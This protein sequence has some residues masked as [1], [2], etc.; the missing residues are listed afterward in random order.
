[1]CC[2]CT[3]SFLHWSRCDTVE[4]SLLKSLKD[5]RSVSD[6]L[7]VMCSGNFY[8][9]LHQSSLGDVEWIRVPYHMCT[10]I[11]HSWHF[12]LGR[13]APALVIQHMF[14]ISYWYNGLLLNT[15]SNLSSQHWCNCKQTQSLIACPNFTFSSSLATVCVN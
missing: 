8:S 15:R 12:C 14:R 3:N 2:F 11:M 9:L 5:F 10:C 6:K 1:M 7:S 4:N 13:F